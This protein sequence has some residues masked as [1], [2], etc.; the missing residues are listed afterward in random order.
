[1]KLL[2]LFK[3]IGAG[4]LVVAQANPLTA[5]IANQAIR[6][7]KGAGL[8]ADPEAELKM[9]EALMGFEKEMADKE[10]RVLEAV[11]KT[12]QTEMQFGNLWQR[13]WRPACG[14]TLVAI[15]INNFIAIP[16]AGAF[17]LP[18]EIIEIP[19]K[20]WQA[21][22]AVNGITAVSRGVEKWQKAKNE[23][24]EK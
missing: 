16:Y 12:I 5:G 17:G 2:K 18:I 6:A 11:N 24:G 20:V 21:L 1:M 14:W 13:S 23:K 10:T 15:I 8:V 9:Q 4:A 3:G 7:L 22:L 19:D